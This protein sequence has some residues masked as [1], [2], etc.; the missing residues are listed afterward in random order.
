M[1]SCFRSRSGHE[2][3]G[4]ARATVQLVIAGE[5]DPGNCVARCFGT[6]GTDP[7]LWNWPYLRATDSQPI[8]CC[9]VDRLRSTTPRRVGSTMVDLVCRLVN[10]R[11]TV[12]IVTPR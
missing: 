12:S 3:E 2:A 11:E 6:L 4:V 8:C 10:V 9:N 1:G 7:E 5:R